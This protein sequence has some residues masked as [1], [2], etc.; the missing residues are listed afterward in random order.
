MFFINI[1]ILG[2][3]NILGAIIDKIYYN[4]C[5]YKV[6]IKIT[7][8]IGVAYTYIFHKYQTMYFNKNQFHYFVFSNCP[9]PYELTT[10]FSS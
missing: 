7:E 10:S 5:S 6:I 9:N 3:I 2:I 4:K 1:P 8:Q